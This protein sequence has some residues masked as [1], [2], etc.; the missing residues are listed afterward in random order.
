[1]W[2][3]VVN[4]LEVGGLAGLQSRTVGGS[5]GPLDAW[6]WRHRLLR[7]RTCL[8]LLALS[9][10]RMRPHLGVAMEPSLLLYPESCPLGESIRLRCGSGDDGASTSLPPGAS[11]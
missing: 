7:L 10:H 9:M 8:A 5:S 1:M 4:T 2:G 11:T 3:G 6:G